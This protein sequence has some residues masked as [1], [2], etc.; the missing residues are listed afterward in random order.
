MAQRL[1][2]VLVALVSISVGLSGSGAAYAQAEPAAED[3]GWFDAPAPSETEDE[4]GAQR[5]AAPSAAPRPATPPRPANPPPPPAEAA[6]DADPSAI[7][8]FKPVLDPYGYWMEHPT[9]GLVWVPHRDHVGKDFAPYVTSG[10]WAL[11]DD[12][13]WMWV[14]DYPFGWVVF[15]Y[16]RWVWVPGTGWAWIPGRQY[17][18]AWVTWRVP[19]GSYA[20]V[21]WA[22]MPPS[23]VWF[24]GVA[25]GVWYT[26]RV[27]Y[28]FC[29]SHYVFSY[30]VH[31]HIVRDRHVI[32]RV[33]AHTR[34]YRPHVPASPRTRAPVST[35]SAPAAAS[36]RSAPTPA[37]A[38]P[39][40][41]SYGVPRGPSLEAARVPKSAV[42]RERVRPNPRAIEVA[43]R[44]PSRS[45]QPASLPASRASVSPGAVRPNVQTREAPAPRAST[46]A[47]AARP[48]P[49]TPRVSP[50]PTP[51]P[52]A[53][54]APH[55]S[56]QP[57]RVTPAPRA[58][59]PRAVAPSR[60]TVRPAPRSLGPSRTPA[61]RA[62]PRQY[63]K[64]RR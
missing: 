56:S 20:Y 37:H 27:A 28:V 17:A 44:A 55:A 16:G 49:S 15:H 14:S 63:G 18:H 3:S 41:G 11:A 57:T 24:G 46:P 9:Y 43:R 47:T 13:E 36:P 26:P 39:S 2:R 45:V 60:S 58:S 7:T 12:G 31:H 5:A 6:A 42:P 64:G 62:L 32:H 21:G 19:T 25:V 54:P 48:Q 40:P 29:P 10:R 23:F 35:R 51:A 4:T 1:T 34:H 22:P 53:A 8:E 38:R 30:H 61:P 52:K 50:A 33:A 59:S